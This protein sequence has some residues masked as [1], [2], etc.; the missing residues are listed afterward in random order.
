MSFLKGIGGA[1]GSL[2]PQQRAMLLRTAAAT[3]RSPAAA[4][5]FGQQA[6][7][8]DRY[9][10]QRREQA[11]DD[12]QLKQ[13]LGFEREK[14]E[15]TLRQQQQARED[16]ARQ[17]AAALADAQSYQHGITEYLKIQSS[18]LPDDQK[19]QMVVDLASGVES[20]KFHEFLA[21][22]AKKGPLVNIDQ[23]KPPDPNAKYM[24]RAYDE[25]GMPDV[26]QGVVPVPGGAATTQTAEQAAKRM[27]YEAAAAVLPAV[28]KMI[29]NEDGSVDR[30]NIMNAQA[31]TPFT[32][33]RSLWGNMEYG[34]QAITRGETGAAMPPEELENTR[35]R[36]SP[37]SF[38]SDEQIKAKFLVYSA[39]I[40][41]TLDL[42]KRGREGNALPVLDQAK[43][44]AALKAYEVNPDFDSSQADD[45]E[46]FK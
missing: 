15:N 14:F 35:R 24:W 11:V 36:F 13:R 7:Q 38:D 2:S 46:S 10:M 33:G 41:G 32:E 30:I 26:S 20:T 29:F 18:G 12:R 17:Q 31:R 22:V 9:E 4:Q 34:I 28:E 21:S 19:E 45:F 5:G 3:T 42:F 25:D 27:G 40:N 37:G 1:I 43:V 16:E 6:Q 8:I 39:M 23:R 44:E